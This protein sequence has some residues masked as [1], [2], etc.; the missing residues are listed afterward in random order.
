MNQFINKK[1]SLIL[2]SSLSILAA[3]SLTAKSNQATQDK[4]FSNNQAQNTAPAI[5]IKWLGLSLGRISPALQSQLAPQLKN[6]IGVMVTGVQADS[7]AE[8]AGLQVFDILTRFNENPISNSQQVYALVQQSNTDDKVT[9]EYIR[10]GKKHTA[11]TKIGSREINQQ[12]NW[13]QPFSGWPN[14]N[15]F[16]GWPNLN[17][18]PFWNAQPQ[19]NHPF[20]QD[21][22][23]KFNRNFSSPF[24]NFPNIPP[25]PSFPKGFNGLNGKNT[26]HF[27]QSE[28]LSM[29]TLGNGEIHLEFK[30][31]D[32]DNNEKN[33]IFEGKR[34][35]IL[36]DIQQQKDLPDAQKQ[37]LID[38]IKGNFSYSFDSFGSGNFSLNN[39]LF[40]QPPS[41]KSEQQKPPKRLNY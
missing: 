25:S 19:W 33:F 3:T 32:T 10:A 26:Q 27:S 37:K 34:E 1:I 20:F 16:G 22:N 7:P 5:Q 14:G 39:G 30:S 8:K 6:G 28:S 12:H 21:F 38:V 18:D 4:Q 24:Y 9:L 29:K 40:A 31:K 23:K 13:S 41:H 2:L 35:Q 11:T 15:G 17:S 36:Q